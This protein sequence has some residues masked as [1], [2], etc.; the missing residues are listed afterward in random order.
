MSDAKLRE[1]IEGEVSTFLGGK[2]MGTDPWDDSLEDV[3]SAWQ[4]LDAVQKACVGRLA[5]LRERLMEEAEAAGTHTKQK[6]HR[7][8]LEDGVTVTRERREDRLPGDEPLRELLQKKGIA[9]RDAYSR[10]MQWVIDPSKLD[11]LIELGKLKKKEVE[12]LKGVNFAMKV[13]RSKLLPALLQGYAPP[14][15]QEELDEEEEAPRAKR[16]AASGA[17]KGK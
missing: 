4:V 14:E 3:V 16:Q 10:K 15:E 5:Q 1:L 2:A 13:V 12:N 11:Q 9:L 7:L 6:G 8:F 17:R